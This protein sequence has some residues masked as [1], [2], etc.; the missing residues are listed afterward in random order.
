MMAPRAGVR[1]SVAACHR[2]GVRVVMITGDHAATAR[3]IA[4]DLGIAP[5]GAAVLTGQDLAGVE[6]DDLRALARTHQV[7]ARVSPNWAW[8]W[9]AAASTWHAKRP[10]SS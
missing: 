6:G 5:A 9:G 7:F 2:A 10:T 8:P 1:E 3:S 4:H